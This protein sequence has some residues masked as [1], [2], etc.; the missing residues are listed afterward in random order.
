MNQLYNAYPC[1]SSPDPDPEP[2]D[3]DQSPPGNY[4]SSAEASRAIVSGPIYP[5]VVENTFEN[6]TNSRALVKTG[7]TP[8][9]NSGNPFTKNGSKSSDGVE[10]GG[11]GREMVGGRNRLV[12]RAA[13]FVTLAGKNDNANSNGNVNGIGELGKEDY[14]KGRKNDNHGYEE[15]DDDDDDDDMDF[16]HDGEDDEEFDP[17]AP[18][19]RYN[20]KNLLEEEWD[21]LQKKHMAFLEEFT[22]DTIASTYDII[23]NTQYIFHQLVVEGSQNL[24]RGVYM[25]EE[26]ERKHEEARRIITDFSNEMKRAAEVLKK[27]GAANPMKAIMGGK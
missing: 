15:T 12:R 19:D 24:V 4:S 7:P 22:K 9:Y 26:E 1:T 6:E 5:D 14:Q 2:F 16:G 13:S 11:V 23:F 10:S 25:I 20:S 18:V 17:M 27:F 3:I 21:N 8:P